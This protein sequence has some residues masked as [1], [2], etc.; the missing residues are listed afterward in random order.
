[1]LRISTTTSIA[2]L[3]L[4][5]VVCGLA[6]KQ[7]P[8]FKELYEKYG[9]KQ[10]T[11]R[12]RSHISGSSFLEVASGVSVKGAGGCEVCVYVVENKQMHQPFLCRGLKD[13]AYQQTCVSALISMMWWLENQVYWIKYGCQRK[14]AN[15]QWEWVK[16]CPAHAVCSWMQNLYDREPFCPLDP[17][18]QKPGRR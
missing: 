14:G 12:L 11:P 5:T 16:P 17:K 8:S 3:F 4:M 18:Y 15:D 10:M 6:D 9:A 2:L 7:Q 1:M 13:P